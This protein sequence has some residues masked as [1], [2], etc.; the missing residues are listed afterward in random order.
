MDSDAIIEAAYAMQK[1]YSSGE[2]RDPAVKSLV[3]MFPEIDTNT[4]LAMWYAIDAYVDME[5]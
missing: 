5:R 4:A 2:Y 3:E 1:A